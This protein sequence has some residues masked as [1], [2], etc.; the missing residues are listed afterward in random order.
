[1]IVEKQGGESRAKYGDGLIKELSIQM[2]KDFGK[3]FSERNLW[4]MKQF[5]LVFPKV[6]AVSSQLSWT[7]CRLHICANSQ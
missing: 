1:M 3:N 4:F 2:T 7:H 5:Y 6:N